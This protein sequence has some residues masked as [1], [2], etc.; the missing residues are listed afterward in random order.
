MLIL[1][2]SVLILAACRRG[3]TED[4]IP[5]TPDYV[6]VPG[7]VPAVD[8]SGTDLVLYTTFS[9]HFAAPV[10]YAFEEATGAR[11]E[12]VMAG[13]GALLER[14]REEA[15]NPQADVFWGGAMFSVIPQK[16]LFE[17]YIS[18]NET[19]MLEVQRNIEGPFTR[20][21]TSGRLMIVNTPLLEELGI[22]IRGYADL[23]QPQLRGRIAIADPATSGS[24]FNHLANQLFAMGNG[25]PNDGWDYI[26]A[27]IENVDGIMLP[28]SSDVY[29]GVINGDFVVG[30]TFEEAPWPHIEGGAP[31][32]VVYIAE[33]IIAT[34]SAVSVVAGAPNRDAARVFIDFVTSY[35]IQ[36]IMEVELFRRPVRADV[37]SQGI[38]PGNEE[39]L[40]L[41][42][43]IEY[44]L[45][46]REAW[47]AK[48]A[49]VWEEV[50]Y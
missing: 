1:A 20:F 8:I 36:S 11:V 27:F 2:A 30:L 3:E 19:H 29:R 37:P 33:G 34:S 31:V 24:S 32:H 25:V 4:Y 5:E 38:L 46:N 16:D 26:R 10:I 42:Y 49:E 48:F 39:L 35:E 14:L 45:D 44:V 12:V 41:D 23:L 40:W 18:A 13:T 9:T 43:N 28:D 17:D 15:D 47:L 7:F 50:N 21:V 22:E 6:V